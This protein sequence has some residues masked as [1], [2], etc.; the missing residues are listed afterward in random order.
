MD[1]KT[2]PNANTGS[3]VPDDQKESLYHNPKKSNNFI[4]RFKTLWMMKESYY[5][6]VYAGYMTIL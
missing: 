4:Q 3:G 2:W 5:L 1:E 6:H